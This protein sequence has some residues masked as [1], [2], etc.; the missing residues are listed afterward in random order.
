MSCYGALHRLKSEL[1]NFEKFTATEHIEHQEIDRFGRPG[2]VKTR[3]FSY[4]VFVDRYA[5]DSF[6][7]NEDRYS[8]ADDPSFPTP[9]ATQGLSNLGVA[10][11]QPANRIDFEFRCEGLASMRGK[12]SWQIRF[13][14]RKDAKRGVRNWW[15]D[16]KLYRVPVK[17]RIWISSAS[18]DVL[19]IETDLRE[20]LPILS[21]TRDHLV[22]DYG[23]V[24]FASSSSTLWLPRDRRNAH[25]AP[26]PPLSSQAL[27]DG[28]HALRSGYQQQNRQA[29]RAASAATFNSRRS[30]GRS[31][32]PRIEKGRLASL[33]RNSKSGPQIV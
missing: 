5:G 12:A 2:P 8:S 7:L 10:I 25:G 4:I 33:L 14:E 15:R 3:A 30:R 18:S 28:L 24:N 21:L 23:P 11:L 32:H 22:V 9:L 27:F 16:G 19:R 29:E 20:P 26:R 17:G 13:E 6:F 1:Q 31:E